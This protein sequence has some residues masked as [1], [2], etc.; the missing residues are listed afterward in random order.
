M[1]QKRE[2]RSLL[3]LFLSFLLI[4]STLIPLVEAEEQGK[5]NKMSEKK[6]SVSD[7]VYDAF[8]ER[9]Y[10]EILVEMKEQVDTSEVARQSKYKQKQ[11][12]LSSKAKQVTRDAVVDSLKQTAE[13]TQ[14]NLLDQLATSP[15]VEDIKSFYIM[16]VVYV[17]GTKEVVD[18]IKK[19]PEVK[20]ITLDKKIEVDWP[21]I[22]KN[23]QEEMLSKADNNYQANGD[24]PSVEWNIDHIDAPQVWNEYGVDGSGVVVGTIDTG[25]HWTHEALKGSWRGYN[26][27]DPNNPNP[28][29]NWFDA[30]EGQGM[31]YDIS[32]PHGTHVLGTI[33]GQEPNGENKIGV[34]PGAKW[35]AARAFTVDG[36]QQSWLLAAGQ[37]MLAP[38][39]DP[40]LAPDI[41]NNSWGG[42]PGIDEWYRPMVQ[43][44]RDAEILPVF[45]AGNDYPA[46]VAAPANYP[47]SY[48]VGATDM[49]NLRGNFSNVGPGPYNGDLKPDIA[50]P[51]VNIRSSVP[52]GYQG[53]WNGTSMATPHISGVAA[54]LRSVDGSLTVDELEEIMNSTA[55]PLTD[56]QYPDTPNFGYGNGLVNAYG[57][58]ST[59]ASGV[60]GITGT[61]LKEG[62]DEEPP[63][64]THEANLFT[65]QSLDFQLEAQVRDNISVV[66]TELYVRQ[67]ET[68]DWE[69]VEFEN[70]GGNYLDG[71][72]EITVPSD[73]V[74]VPGF[75]YMI[76]ATDFSGNVTETDIYNVEVAFGIDPSESFDHSFESELEG[77]LLTEDW[78]RG[79]PIVG[80]VPT[81]GENVVGTNLE[82]NYSS[83]SESFLQLPP[84]DLRNVEAASLSMKHWFDI[85]YTYDY[86]TIYVTDDI[87]SEEWY[88]VESFSGRE[89]EWKDFTVDLSNYANSE[90][91][92]FIAF[93][94]ETDNQVNHSG[95]YLDELSISDSAIGGSTISEEAVKINDLITDDSSIDS[96]STIYNVP[97]GLPAE[98]TVTV[99]ETGK[100]TKTSL[101]D[102][103]YNI[104]HSPTNGESYTLQVEAYGYY[105]QE[106]EFEL[107]EEETI[108]ENF[109]LQE[110]PKGEIEVTVVD[111]NQMPLEGVS[112]EVLEDSRIS[113]TVTDSNGVSTLSNVLEGSYTLRV[114]LDN[115][116]FEQVA[117]DVVGGETTQLD[118]ELNR[119]P[120][121]AIKYDD[122]IPDNARVF[123]EA[124]YGFVTKMTPDQF[125]FV[126]GASFYLWGEDWPYP[127]GN[128]FSVTIYDSDEDGN[129]GQRVFEPK[130]VEGIR[131]EWNYV[132]LNEYNF[133][134]DQDYYVVMLQ[135][136]ESTQSPGIGVDESG[137]FS[138]RTYIVDNTGTFDKLGEQYGNFM[139]RSHVEYVTSA[140]VLDD[141][142]NI[143]YTNEDSY[144]VTGSV[145]EDGLV[146]IYNKGVEVNTGESSNNAFSFRVPLQE[147]ENTITATVTNNGIESDASE[148]LIVVQDVTDPELNVQSLPTSTN[149]ETIV[150]YGDV[151]D[152]NLDGV[153]V[154][155]DRIEV[156]E[157]SSFE[158]EIQLSEGHN[159]V[160]VVGIDL[161][162]NSTETT[163]GVEL[164]TIAPEIIRITPNEDEYLIPG[165]ALTVSV[166]TDTSE[167]TATIVVKDEDENTVDE[168]SMVEVE[169]TI[170]E[171]EWTPSDNIS[172]ATLHLELE[173]RAGNKSNAKTDGVIYVGDQIARIYGENRYETAVEISRLGWSTSD[174]VILA[175]GDVYADALAG[176]PLAHQLDAPVLLTQST[177]LNEITKNEL[178]RLQAK[179]V[180]ILGGKMAID[181]Q[182]EN[183][184]ID[185]GL[186][187]DRIAGE[188]RAETAKLIAEKLNFDTNQAI[189]VNGWNFPDAL[190][191]AT[192][193]ATEEI[194]ILLSSKDDLPTATVDFIG[195]NNVIETIVVGG[196]SA[197][198]SKVLDLLPNPIRISGSDRYQT[199]I[200]LFNYF[201]PQTSTVYVATGK[202]FADALTGA[203]LSAKHRAGI[204]LTNDKVPEGTKEFLQEQDVKH[205]RILG[206]P[207]AVSDEVYE[208]LEN[209]LN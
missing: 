195:A 68:V 188:K 193:A 167:G 197:V 4:F 65:Y 130:S 113:S 176:I 145:T 88:E 55:T 39:D 209:L 15:Q 143:N 71:H 101:R 106:V 5:S 162:G 51:G 50:A 36:G 131:G 111:Q 116:Q 87:H 93:L 186:E 92:V 75:Q 139:I 79:V 52:G 170:Y 179:K 97:E 9:E 25:A 33:L 175:R 3:A 73:F 173:D 84:L 30:V 66:K 165:E 54:L 183:E 118:V 21:T 206:G 77:M 190:S 160:N 123:N 177:K 32:Q 200:A 40:S 155:G 196:P 137:P 166:T 83:Q 187:V 59:V 18:R 41:I 49:N 184:L 136:N 108:E 164:D 191:V 207:E 114:A 19:N 159:S 26:S 28:T 43:A 203:T 172:Q 110:I 152:P 31:P 198:D 60:G 208:E 64:M 124:G 2:M 202:K 180:I 163:L 78:Q 46:K 135:T 74:E 204:L 171:A 169:P 168:L 56:N 94:L 86:G 129:P 82:G 142:S 182:V 24:D 70:V 6:A 134:T 119:F 37:F 205:L 141:T 12:L 35:I 192:F 7:E 112:I 127:G 95:W 23:K 146:T 125:A 61:V 104:L 69:I 29:G 47:E 44:W 98:A 161:A 99:V 121:N 58:V 178:E 96:S 194:P 90:N 20:R 91:Q 132:D 149:E 138:D 63:E 148:V 80:P 174:T 1:R 11:N 156:K 100:T 109:L 115:Y 45:A 10:V 16:N 14:K 181:K 185:S 103:S 102:G 147:G 8:K 122:G 157:D 85:E 42:G 38:N 153:M 67:E 105:S 76:K 199:N 53:G 89:R 158:Y 120:G 133:K 189:V 34:A 27:L 72:Y 48:A 62:N 126:T 151:S 154:N 57:A 107:G 128:E 201:L 81:D 22:S 17:K 140:P 150:L 144:E 13:K 117:I